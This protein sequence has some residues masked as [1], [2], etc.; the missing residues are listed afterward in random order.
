MKVRESYLGYGDK[1]LNQRQVWTRAA[2]DRTGAIA[3]A[4]K[5]AHVILDLTGKTQKRLCCRGGSP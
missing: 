5:W 2:W 4:R 1:P 3:G